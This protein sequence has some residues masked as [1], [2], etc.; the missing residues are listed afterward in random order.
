MH[1][2]R[3]SLYDT[4][5]QFFSVWN[6]EQNW[7]EGTSKPKSDAQKRQ[8]SHNA[9]LSFFSVQFDAFLRL[10][11]HFITDGQRVNERER[12]DRRGR[13]K[14]SGGFSGIRIGWM[15]SESKEKHT[16][17]NES[18]LYMCRRRIHNTA[19]FLMPQ[20]KIHKHEC[21]DFNRLWISITRFLIFL[22]SSVRC[23][24]VLLT[25]TCCCRSRAPTQEIL[26]W[27][28]GQFD[29]LLSYREQSSETEHKERMKNKIKVENFLTDACQDQH[30]LSYH[31]WVMIRFN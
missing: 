21:V 25:L 9:S 15:E 27:L 20:L 2:F 17:F 30:L 19:Y 22:V 29:C 7:R 4:Q 23:V 14:K 28:T 18:K 12:L 8:T 26:F 13:K 3:A 11:Y 31:Y 10:F 24:V 1:V 6:A 16:K 5:Y